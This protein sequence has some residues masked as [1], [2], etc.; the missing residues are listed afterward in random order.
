MPNREGSGNEVKSVTVAD[1]RKRLR[2]DS[3]NP[4][5]SSPSRK[6]PAVNFFTKEPSS[7]TKVRS[8][9]KEKET[10]HKIKKE[11]ELV[12]S[13]SEEED[14]E[15]EEEEEDEDDEE[16][17]E[18]EDSYTVE[19]IK[20]HNF[21]KK[22]QLLFHIKWLGYDKPEDD[23]WEPESNLIGAREM[24][25]E[26]LEKIGGRPQPPR[27]R[28][29]P[30]RKRGVAIRRRRKRT[31][32]DTTK[33]ASDA[34]GWKTDEGSDLPLGSWETKIKEIKSISMTDQ[35]KLLFTI[36]WA[37]GKKD[38]AVEAQVLYNKA[39]QKVLQ[40]YESHIQFS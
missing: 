27:K 4:S 13:E 12:E 26:Y 35:G 19:A 38:G 9:E 5:G 31:P 18:D 37:D 28:G 6:P 29:E 17:D 23:S 24:V 2:T 34:N 7:A 1:S 14:G 21:N 39:P 3:P 16:E 20:G 10:A 40:F 30:P 11:V 33:D 32:E 36:E 15:E 25:D 8:K 22:G